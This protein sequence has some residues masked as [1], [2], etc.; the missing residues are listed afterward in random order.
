MECGSPLPASLVP[1]IRIPI[2]LSCSLCC[3]VTSQ[4]VPTEGDTSTT[5]DHVDGTDG[6][7]GPRDRNGLGPAVEPTALLRAVAMAFGVLAS[8]VVDEVRPAPIAPLAGTSARLALLAAG[9]GTEPVVSAISEEGRAALGARL[10]FHYA[11]V[12][13]RV[14]VNCEHPGHGEPGCS[15]PLA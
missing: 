6:A 12:L 1:I 10:G 5:P 14:A 3:Y 13:L 7:Y 15:V 9:R 4:T 11:S 8:G 2:S